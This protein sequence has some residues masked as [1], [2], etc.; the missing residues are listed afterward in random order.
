MLNQTGIKKTK[1]AAPTQI[2]FSVEHQMSVSVLVDK[3]MASVLVD[4]RKVVKAGTPLAGS[5]VNRATAFK[6]PTGTDTH[7][8]GVLLHDVDITDG[9]ANGSLL[10]WGFVNLN[11]VDTATAALVNADAIS[12]LKG[13]VYFL[14]DN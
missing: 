6:A 3:T 2:L 1:G 13:Q 4:G 11:R 14:K 9:N 7:A 12:S 8:V 5:L 10:I